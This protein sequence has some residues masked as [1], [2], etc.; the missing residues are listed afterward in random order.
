MRLLDLEA[1]ASGQ[2]GRRSVASGKGQ[3]H[4]KGV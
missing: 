4:G 1:I 2:P 3:I